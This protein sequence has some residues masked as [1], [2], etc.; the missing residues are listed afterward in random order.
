MLP[1]PRQRSS[2]TKARI[3]AAARRLFAAEGYERTT[4]RAIA[5]AAEADPA[6][7]VRY[8]GGKEGLFA[9]A[10]AFDLRL[11]D[12]SSVP[13]EA[14][15]AALVR[16]F[17][18]RWE[19]DP[20]DHALRILLRTAVTNPEA[21]GRMR[22]I[23]SWQLLP[24]MARAAPDGEGER[25]AGLVAS[26]VLGFAFCRY[27]LELPAVAAMDREAVVASLGPTLQRYLTEACL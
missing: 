15:G 7:V 23:F 16:H 11:P 1:K 13:R 4:V 2:D 24:A 17:L 21:A 3:L 22:D 19:G 9:L 10:A 25:R 20:D 26:Q 14:R 8:F 12:M 5:A 27:V 6:L 18:Q